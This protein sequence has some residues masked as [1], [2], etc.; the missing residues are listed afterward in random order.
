MSEEIRSGAVGTQS[1][2]VER[3]S[4]DRE[5]IKVF[6]FFGSWFGFRRKNVIHNSAHRDV[7]KR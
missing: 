3:K 2:I 6:L 1:D 4:R 7:S 5:V